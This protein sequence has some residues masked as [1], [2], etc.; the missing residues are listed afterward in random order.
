LDDIV[1]GTISSRESV[2]T[3]ARDYVGTLRAHMQIEEAEILPLAGR[4]LTTGDWSVIHAA[5]D[6][7][8]DPLFG[9]HPEGR[10][11]ALHQQIAREAHS[12]VGG[13]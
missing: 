9:K 2:E 7:I 6:H 5:I 3:I 1:N 13:G 10:Y 8:E 4:L 11:T 12:P